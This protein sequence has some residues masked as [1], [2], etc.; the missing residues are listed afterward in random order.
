MRK[1]H[2]RKS[3]KGNMLPFVAFFLLALLVIF[4][5]MYSYFAA[6]TLAAEAEQA[7]QAAIISTAQSDY[8]RLYG[9]LRVGYSGRY[10][11]ED[12]TP[13]AYDLDAEK[14]AE[15]VGKSMGMD[16]KAGEDGIVCARYDEDGAAVISV[17]KM[18]GQ[19]KNPTF[20][21]EGGNAGGTYTLTGTATVEIP[22]HGIMAYADPIVI[23]ISVA[24]DW[25][26]RF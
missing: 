24:A 4:Y 17:S 6:Y 19:V 12:G 15:A 10:E 22:F 1:I 5:W 3:G 7:L 18:V 16:P 25:T 14:V 11:D 26:P 20:A 2:W 13:K 9:A 8:D 21:P 23:D